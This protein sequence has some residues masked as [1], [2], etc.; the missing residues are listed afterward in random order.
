MENIRQQPE[1]PTLRLILAD[2][3]DDHAEC[4]ADRARADI[5]RFQ[6]RGGADPGV[7]R[8][9]AT[10]ANQWLGPLQ[11][12]CQFVTCRGGLLSL[13]IHGPNLAARAFQQLLESEYWAWVDELEIRPPLPSRLQLSALMRPI[14]S[15]LLPQMPSNCPLVEWAQAGWLQRL[16]RLDLSGWHS[17]LIDVENVFLPAQLTQLQELIFS[18]SLLSVRSLRSILRLRL[19]RLVLSR[20]TLGDAEVQQLASEPN[21]ASVEELDLTDNAILDR[22]AL[23]LVDSPYLTRIQVLTLF[24]NLFGGEARRRLRERFGARVLFV[25]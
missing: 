9:Q 2:W 7:R 16:R 11:P 23:A 5:L 12:Y 18:R 1:E 20:A 17:S 8:L 21:L 10:F 13:R 14:S 15:L 25:G 6:V 22:G 19:R 3:L 24:G 4:Q